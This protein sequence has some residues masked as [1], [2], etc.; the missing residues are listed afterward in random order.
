MPKTGWT[1]TTRTSF[2]T[3]LAA[4]ATVT[5]NFARRFL[6]R[7]TITARIYWDNKPY[8]VRDTYD[9]GI[10]LIGVYLTDK[11][12]ERNV[13]N[14]LYTGDNSQVT[15]TDL[16]PGTYIIQTDS[17]WYSQNVTEQFAEVT[18]SE[19]QNATREIGVPRDW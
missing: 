15:F 16:L 12:T 13:G 7:A 1:P 17:Y 3:T 9:D 10:Y 19:G 11:A 6:T 14:K 18:V 4:G 8:G 2:K 5:H